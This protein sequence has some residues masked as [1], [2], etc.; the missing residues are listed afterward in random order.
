MTDYEEQLRNLIKD[1]VNVL[2]VRGVLPLTGNIIRDMK[3]V[4]YICKDG[5]RQRIEAHI[6]VRQPLSSITLLDKLKDIL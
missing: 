2:E 4:R 5:L 6:K 1:E 3:L